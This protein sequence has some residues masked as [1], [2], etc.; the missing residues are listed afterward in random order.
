MRIANIQHVIIGNLI[1]YSMETKSVAVCD[2]FFLL[3]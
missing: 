1:S 3:I 2:M